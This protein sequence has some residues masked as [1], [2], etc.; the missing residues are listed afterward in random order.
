MNANFGNQGNG[1]LF[2]N[3]VKWLAR[4]ENFIAIKTK[5]PSDRAITM[6]EA[7]GRTVGIIVM[8][9]FPGSVLVAGIVV[10]SRRRK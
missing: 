10:W 9:L 2:V 4:D 5:S 8:I 6:T 1:N 7:G 3:T